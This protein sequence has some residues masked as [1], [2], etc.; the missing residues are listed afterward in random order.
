MNFT[1]AWIFAV[2]GLTAAGLAAWAWF[3]VARVTDE[4]RSF[5]SLEGM[6]FE[7]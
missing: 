2:A 1:N 4:L 3:A 5:D 6:H 7:V